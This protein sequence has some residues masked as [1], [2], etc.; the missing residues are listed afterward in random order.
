MFF[1][2]VVLAIGVVFLLQNLGFISSG[3]W[4]IIWPCILIAMGLSMMCKKSKHYIC[5]C[6]SEKK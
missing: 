4:G 5:G 1:G 3:V 2:I 6:E